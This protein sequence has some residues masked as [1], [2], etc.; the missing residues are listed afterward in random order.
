MNSQA[1]FQREMIVNDRA[2]LLRYFIIDRNIGL[3]I[4]IYTDYLQNKSI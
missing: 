2:A 1:D 3:N 4:Y